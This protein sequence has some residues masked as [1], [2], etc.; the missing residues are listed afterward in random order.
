MA[1][2]SVTTFEEFRAS[3]GNALHNLN[4]DTHKIMLVNTAPAASLATPDSADFSGTEVSGTG[5]TA[6]GETAAISAAEV[7]G[8]LTVTLD[9]PITWT[10]NAAG[11]TDIKYAVIYSTTAASSDAIGFMDMTADSGTTAIS[12]VDGDITIAA[13]T[14]FTLA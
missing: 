5:Y 1:Q 6:G 12:L 14:I 13:G 3:L 7:G 9:T 10:K 4:T 11:P 8:T 2:G